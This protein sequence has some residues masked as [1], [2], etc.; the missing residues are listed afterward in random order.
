M[1]GWHMHAQCIVAKVPSATQ[2]SPASMPPAACRTHLLAA[3]V[4]ILV[5]QPQ[6]QTRQTRAILTLHG[7]VHDGD[8]D[9]G[10]LPTKDYSPR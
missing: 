2:C 4:L 1:K 9:K 10:S 3:L 8:V 7:M 6:R 5:K